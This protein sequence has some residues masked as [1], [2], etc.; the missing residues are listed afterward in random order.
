MQKTSEQRTVASKK[1]SKVATFVDK[2]GESSA[3][4]QSWLDLLPAGDYGSS[5]CGVFGRILLRRDA[6]FAYLSVTS[7][8][9]LII[10]RQAAEQSSKVEQALTSRSG[11]PGELTQR[12]IP[13]T[14]PNPP[15][16]TTH[17]FPDSASYII[18]TIAQT[19]NR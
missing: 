7:C 16:H 6:Y 9:M 5:I 1:R 10:S 19:I 3:A 8:P 11:L 17:V 4:F 13:G 14:P 15:T 2:I 18:L 12:F